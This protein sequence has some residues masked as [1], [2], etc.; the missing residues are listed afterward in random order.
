MSSFK[1]KLEEIF[2]ADL[3]SLAALRVAMAL[4]VLIDL[5]QRSQDL[6]AHYTDFGV[7]PR[8]AFLDKDVSRWLVSVHLM[9]GTWEFQALLFLVAG[10]FAVALLVGYRTRAVTVVSWFL[11][12]SLQVRNVMIL[13]T[14]DVLLGVVLF[15][16]M[17]L[18]W[19]ACYSVDR[20]MGPEGEE[21]SQRILSVATFAYF[22][23]MVFVYWF[24]ALHRNSPEWLSEGSAVYYALS[25]DQLATPLAHYLLQ[26]PTLLRLLTHAVFWFEIT[27]PLLLFTP[28]FVGPVRTLVLFLFFLMHV[29][30]RLC[31]E[32][33]IFWAISAFSMI[34]LLPSWFWNKIFAF[35]RTRERL[36]TRIYYD[37]ECGFCLKSARLIRTFFLL[38]E[39][40]LA[41]AQQEPAITAEMER[42]NSWVVVDEQGRHHFGYEALL[43][44]A[45]ISPLLWPFVPVLKLLRVGK[46]GERIYGWIA[47]HRKSACS[48]ET[49]SSSS[50]SGW[51]LSLPTTL[52]V[53]FLLAYVFVW[54]VAGLPGIKIIIPER[55]RSLGEMTQL[56]QTWNVFSPFPLKEDGWYVIPGRLK[57][58][59]L[60]DLFKGGEAVTWNKPANVADTFESDRWRKYMMNL[61][62][63]VYKQHRLYYAQYLCR[64]WN[65]RH[66]PSE[67]LEELE[68][69]FVQETT[70][71]NN[72]VAPLKRISLLRHSCD[73]PDVS[74]K[75]E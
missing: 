61:W 31:L 39:T 22:M 47:S 23:Q 60:V 71:P 25:I 44:V 45:R 27:G 53:A 10:I 56:D 64:D 21:V 9:N 11:L 55:F 14:G 28:F 43:V 36:E 34:G 3:R 26:F 1:A 54:N 37:G 13:Q 35:L 17:F 24:T 41:P 59:E 74:N 72:R 68:I 4:L 8:S 29:G 69:I 18:P 30:F 58:G 50:F 70:L 67:R 20:A 19:G 73:K 51:R 42:Q 65:A 2:G 12:I 7:L 48:A 15:W 49:V 52:I 75:G 16:A 46:M 5:V 63:P 40:R 62:Y 6:V 38:P 57:D 32:I 33:G 66:Y